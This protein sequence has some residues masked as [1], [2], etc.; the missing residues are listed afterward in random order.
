MLALLKDHDDRRIDLNSPEIVRLSR[1]SGRSY[2][3]QA[4]TAGQEYAVQMNVRDLLVLVYAE[5]DQVRAVPA[6]K[7]KTREDKAYVDVVEEYG[8]WSLARYV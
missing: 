5:P 1:S 2:R 7:R 6:P 8:T 4:L 3:V